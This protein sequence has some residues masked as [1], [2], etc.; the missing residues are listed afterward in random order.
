MKQTESKLWYFAFLFFLTSCHLETKQ[1]TDQVPFAVTLNGDAVTFQFNERIQKLDVNKIPISFSPHLAC[2]WVWLNDQILRCVLD[3]YEFEYNE[4]HQDTSKELIDNTTYTVKI[5]HGFMNVDGQ[6]LSTSVSSFVSS[7]PM[8]TGLNVLKW[9]SPV[10]PIFY[11]STN[12]EINLKKVKANSFV[13]VH[14]DQRHELEL[15]EFDDYSYLLRNHMRQRI[16]RIILLTPKEDLA[17]DTTYQLSIDDKVKPLNGDVTSLAEITRFNIQTYPSINQITSTYCS[18]NH[19]V[20]EE[21]ELP[22]FLDDYVFLESDIPLNLNSTRYCDKLAT[23]N[24]VNQH[25]FEARYSF[26]LNDFLNNQGDF[27]QCFADISDI[28]GQTND[29]TK[30]LNLSFEN[31]FRPKLNLRNNRRQYVHDNEEVTLEANTINLKEFYVHI[32]RMNQTGK[33]FGFVQQVANFEKNKEML[34]S[35]VL[36][37]DEKIQGVSG[38][39]SLTKESEITIPF[40]LIK[41][42]FHINLKANPRYVA[43]ML[44]DAQTL[45]PISST[46]VVIKTPKLTYKGTTDKAGFVQIEISPMDFIDDNPI[47]DLVM[48]V[49]YQGQSYQFNEID[50][51]ADRFAGEN[52]EINYYALEEGELLV[53]GL[54]N[55]PIYRAG[56]KVEYKFYIRE[57]KDNKFI[58]PEN[59]SSIFTYLEAHSSESGYDLYCEDYLDCHSFFQQEITELDEFG[60]V[61]GEFTL[62]LSARNAEFTFHFEYPKLESEDDDSWSHHDEKYINSEVHFQ[63]TDFQT[64]PYLLTIKSDATHAA[65]EKSLKLFAE[66]NYYSGGPVI[67][68]VGEITVETIGKSITEDFPQYAEYSFPE[69]RECYDESNFIGPLRYDKEGLINTDFTPVAG[70]VGYGYLRI[71]SGIKPENGS[72]TYSQNLVVPYHQNDYFVGM[73]LNQYQYKINEPINL[74][75]ILLNYLGQTEDTSKFNY[76]LGPYIENKPVEF[77]KLTCKDQQKCTTSISRAG[78]YH[79]KAQ[80]TL[81]DLTYEHTISAYIIDP[82]RVQ[83]QN[84]KEQPL[85]ITNKEIYQVGDLAEIKIMFPFQSF[86]SAVFI[87]R[88]SILNHWVNSSDDG[89]MI[90]TFPITAEHVPGFSVTTAL[91]SAAGKAF[92]TAYSN[93]N[94]HSLHI[95][96]VDAETNDHFS[97]KTDQETYAPGDSITLEVASEFSSTAEYTI[98]IID[99]AVISLI[100]D[101]FYYDLEESSLQLATKV[102]QTMSRYLMFPKDQAFDEEG[103]AII[104]YGDEEAEEQ[105]MITVTGSR[106]TR[107]D[108]GSYPP[109]IKGVPLNRENIGDMMIHDPD[110]LSIGNLNI[111]KDQLRTLFKE[112]AY[113][114]TD[115]VIQA[116]EKQSKNIKLPDNIGAWRIIVVGTDKSGELEL[117]TQTIQASK[118]L[119]MFAVLPEQLTVNDQFTGQIQ[120]I[121]K[122]PIKTDLKLVA[123]AVANGNEIALSEHTINA[124][125]INQQYS[126]P[127]EVAVNDTKTI[128]IMAI[129]KTNLAEDGLFKK[130]PVRDMNV[131]AREQLYG[132]FSHEDQQLLIDVSNR[133]GQAQG[134]LTLHLS[135]SIANHLHPT[136]SFMENYPHGCWEQIMARATASAIHLNMF[137]DE[138]EELNKEVKAKVQAIIDQSIDFQASN[139]G[140]TFFGAKKENVSPFLTFHTH[141]MLI[142]LSRMGYQVPTN[143]LDH[144]ISF[145]RNYV[146]DYQDYVL[147]DHYHYLTEQSNFSPELF[148]MAIGLT[149]QGSIATQAYQD[150]TADTTNLSVASLNQL[151]LLNKASDAEPF[152]ETLSKRYFNNGQFMT[153]LNEPDTEWFNMDSAIKSQCET[154]GVLIERQQDESEKVV[155]YQHLSN[156]LNNRPTTGE[157][158]S[159]LENSICLLV[160]KKFIS[161]YETASNDDSFVVKINQ[162]S[163]QINDQYRQTLSVKDPISIN[164]NN[165]EHQQVYYSA[166]LKYEQDASFPMVV[167]EG[168]EIER[169]Y[170]VFNRG[171]WQTQSN[172]KFKIGDWVKTEITVTNPIQRSYI[173]VSSPNPG[174]WV[175]VNPLLNTSVPVGI[176]NKEDQATN[177]SYFYERQLKP[178]TSLFYADFLPAGVHKITYYS[179]VKVAGKFSVLPA[180]I[181][182]MYNSAIR[183]KTELETV[184]VMGDKKINGK[185]EKQ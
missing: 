48:N 65:P 155:I 178:A 92:D 49:N 140:M 141:K 28:F 165:P 82:N 158:G 174:A 12:T 47:D 185:G 108:L 101:G 126:L 59:L 95:K 147:N 128:E 30:F 148:F 33:E 64:S 179:Q 69:C 24:L 171:K 157:F 31:G 99:E 175:P 152:L 130:I 9:Q 103:S 138:H 156:V 98:A 10:R 8:I 45:A 151:V 73:K 54:T 68:Q 182:A 81:N 125:D 77:K 18:P 42:P 51:F 114:K 7:R 22:C 38:F 154:A 1:V 41:S 90:I 135:T 94:D 123:N 26:K 89:A 79:F 131:A 106:I 3:P 50:R 23:M 137:V 93:Y 76:F 88:N 129:A 56:E 14:K 44:H 146:K 36:P 132:Q 170:H 112:S 39:I 27:N 122:S 16:D 133:A 119:E 127:V 63:V 35:I 80:S 87:E 150:L 25:R 102:W 61:S 43:V 176:I 100:D 17:Y 60:S 109:A 153:L 52:S 118:D 159:T 13:L 177:S 91:I 20:N 161:Q 120:A 21:A 115:W 4:S 57:K 110:Q 162:V 70:D 96:V 184:K 107:K 83:V 58:I 46:E 169:T 19:W 84:E 117:Q 55:K 134:E 34:T 32:D 173:A 6:E 172:D 53:W 145:A 149:E 72:W 86:K 97:F 75:S 78:L 71:N 139:G 167:G 74:E 37:V 66:A 116:G 164:V 2:Q 143:V 136:F 62:P 142:E 163:K 15:L 85:I 144:I 40:D 160:F 166:E 181:E 111:N 124:I 5:G 113:F 29:F 104:D 121:S 11:A 67:N 105:G 180:T 183:A 168:L